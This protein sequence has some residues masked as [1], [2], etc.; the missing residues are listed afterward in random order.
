[1]K[2]TLPRIQPSVP[3]GFSS[4]KLTMLERKTKSL[5]LAQFH[6]VGAPWSMATDR[7]S[8][9]QYPLSTQPVYSYSLV[10]LV[11]FRRNYPATPRGGTTHRRPTTCTISK[12]NL[13]HYTG[14]LDIFSHPLYNL[15][16]YTA[17]A[18]A[19]QFSNHGTHYTHHLRG[20]VQNWTNHRTTGLI[21]EDRSNKGYSASYNTRFPFKSS[22]SDLLEVRSKMSG[23]S[24]PYCS[25]L[26]C[27]H[28]YP[29]PPRSRI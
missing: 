11:H 5:F 21:S 18:L 19:Q 22:A 24:S 9:S 27:I 20:N 25:T 16:Y 10:V 23:L 6:F 17:L 3:R 14:S 4:Y 8:R 1:M 15:L 29:Q 7:L 26:T 13:T 28:A 2:F 12:L